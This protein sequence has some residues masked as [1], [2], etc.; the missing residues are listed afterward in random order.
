MASNSDADLLTAFRKMVT[1][2]NQDYFGTNPQNYANGLQGDMAANVKMKRI[3]DPGYYDEATPTPKPSG[4]GEVKEYFVNGNGNGSKHRDTFTPDERPEVQIIDSAGFV[5][6]SATFVDDKA[7]RRIAYSFAF[8]YS[9]ADGGSWKAIHL[10]GKD[11]KN[12]KDT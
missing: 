4:Y 7:T 1:D 6:G 9:S 3:D 12:I 5:S 11:K 10:W 8:T 2:F